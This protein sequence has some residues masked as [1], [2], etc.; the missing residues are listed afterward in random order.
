LRFW[1]A[2]AIAATTWSEYKKYFEK[3][4]ALA[5]RFQVV[6]VEEPI[7][8][9]CMTMLRGIVPSLE[10]HHKVR[11]LDEGLTA[12]VHLSHRYL[13][14]RQLPD[15][16]V[17]VLD[18]A[19]ARLALG[20]SA[21]PPAIEDSV[22]Q[23]DDSRCSN[24]SSSA[25]GHGLTCERLQRSR[26]RA[27]DRFTSPRLRTRS[28][29]AGSGSAIRDLHLSSKAP[30]RRTERYIGPEFQALPPKRNRLPRP[31]VLAAE[32]RCGGYSGR[33]AAIDDPAELRAKP[34]AESNCVAANHR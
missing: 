33:N 28:E 25:D 11:I 4:P 2:P 29:R 3:D 1:F 18:T 12:A 17:S 26:R 15:K 13:A 30:P 23:L 24:G 21:T 14:G 19:C 27:R 8:T 31:P 34:E 10:K 7:E 6:K 9:Q 20:Q 5:R 22:R 32:P 16:A